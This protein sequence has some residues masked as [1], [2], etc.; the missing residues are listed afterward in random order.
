ME[1]IETDRLT[2]RPFTTEDLEDVQREVFSDPDVC[3]F[4]CRKTRTREETA[5]W[6]TYRI[7]EWKYSRFGRLAVV[8]KDTQEFTGF[9]GLE[10]YPNSFSR[11]PDDPQPLYNEVEV[12][13][14]FA[15]G[16]RYWGKGYASEASRAMIRYAFD[17][18][19]LRQLVGGAALENER[20]R[21]LQERLGFRV[22]LNA[23]PDWPGY[24]TVLRNDTV[25]P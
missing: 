18:L 17:D 1:A 25:R 14:S 6:L 11:F 3:H 7:T 13:L 2:L 20:S 22:V 4:Y 21:R 5:E 9:V 19:K 16:K 12:E 24:V 10:A 23:H 8:L 15:F